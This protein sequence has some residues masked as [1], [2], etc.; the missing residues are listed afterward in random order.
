MPRVDHVIYGV[1]DLDTAA[2]RLAEAFGLESVEGGVHPHFGTRNRLVGL[3]DTYIELLAGPPVTGLLRDGPDRLLGWVVR[4]DDIDADAER[5]GLDIVGMTRVR[6][7]GT[8]LAWRLAG[9][10]MGGP[11]PVF[12]Q[13]ETPWEP[14]GDARLEWVEVS[15]SPLHLREW[16][17][18]DDLPVRY[19]AGEAGVHAVGIRLLDGREVVVR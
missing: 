17:G 1:S 9:W 6:P 19:T 15:V 8:E 16:V 7:D 5:L 18:H 10:G 3:G 4:T 12:I 14:G 13:W 2:E 11:L